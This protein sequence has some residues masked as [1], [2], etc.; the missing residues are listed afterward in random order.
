MRMVA[1]P[2]AAKTLPNGSS[3]AR[4]ALSKVHLGADPQTEK[5]TARPPNA[6]LALGFKGSFFPPVALLLDSL[7]LPLSF[8]SAVAPVL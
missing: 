5:A 2:P 8:K 3:V 6:K 7:A 1:M 4:S